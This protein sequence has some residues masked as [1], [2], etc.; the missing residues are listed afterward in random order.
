MTFQA[1][2]FI[3]KK[4]NKTI[5]TIPK[6]NA[7]ALAHYISISHTTVDVGSRTAE[8]TAALTWKTQLMVHMI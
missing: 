2:N 8:G 5:I 7:E 1:K 4:P 3:D 6:P